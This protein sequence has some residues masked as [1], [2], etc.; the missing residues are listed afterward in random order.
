MGLD[1]FKC[2]RKGTSY[3]AYYSARCRV[4]DRIVCL[5]SSFLNRSGWCLVMQLLKE[6]C[7]CCL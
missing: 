7:R 3:E 5:Q 4:Y 1:I 2:K 6:E